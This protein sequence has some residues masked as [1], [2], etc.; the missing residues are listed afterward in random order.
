M[1]GSVQL[2]LDWEVILVKYISR[3]FGCCFD[4]DKF[5]K[6]KLV[7][8]VIFLFCKKSLLYLEV[9]LSCFIENFDEF[10]L[11]FVLFKYKYYYFIFRK[12]EVWYFDL[13]L[14]FVSLGLLE[15][16]I[17]FVMLEYCMFFLQVGVF[18]KLSENEF[19]YFKEYF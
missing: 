4:F 3:L 18:V 12:F 14:K 17:V 16:F 7:V 11:C 13:S 9:M 8:C 5:D 6:Q 1:E 2:F 15:M 10:K 19:F